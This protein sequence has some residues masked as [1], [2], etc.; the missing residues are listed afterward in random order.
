MTQTAL[1]GTKSSLWSLKNADIPC[2]FHPLKETLDQS[3]Q[4]LSRVQL[5]ATP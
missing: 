5:F 3:V 4:S 1:W 2:Q